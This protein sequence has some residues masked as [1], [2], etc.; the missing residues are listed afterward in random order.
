MPDLARVIHPIIHHPS[1][2]FIHLVCLF[3]CLGVFIYRFQC[4]TYTFSSKR[5]TLEPIMSQYFSSRFIHLYP[6]PLTRTFCF[7]PPFNPPIHTHALTHTHTHVHRPVYLRSSSPSRTTISTWPPH[8]S[9][10][11]LLPTS[12]PPQDGPRYSL[13]YLTPPAARIPA[14]VAAKVAAKVVATVTVTTVVG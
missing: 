3:V 4:L 9:T 1:Q 13:P 6:L 8:F 10:Q 12:T 7:A 5:P 2:C 14:R 11:A